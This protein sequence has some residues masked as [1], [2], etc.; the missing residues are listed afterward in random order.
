MTHHICCRVNEFYH[1][2]IV[3]PPIELSIN[4]L[5]QGQALPRTAITRMVW[6]HVCKNV[7]LHN[8]DMPIDKRSP[9][10][11]VMPLALFFYVSYLVLTDVKTLSTDYIRRRLRSKYSEFDRQQNYRAKVKVAGAGSIRSSH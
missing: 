7:V 4:S 9:N 1:V 8:S 6:F 10:T 2:D 11:T 5:G 3:W